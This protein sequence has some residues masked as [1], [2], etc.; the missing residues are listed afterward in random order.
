MVININ[1]N[2]LRSKSRLMEKSL[3]CVLV[4]RDSSL[5]GTFVGVYTVCQGLDSVIEA[6][7]SF[8]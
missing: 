7:E 6:R 3:I 5:S 1:I 2:I 8:S 4:C